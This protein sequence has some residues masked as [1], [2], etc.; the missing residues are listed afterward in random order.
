[1]LRAPE[2]CLGLYPAEEAGGGRGLPPLGDT[3]V[4]F[5]PGR[6]SVSTGKGQVVTDLGREFSTRLSE[7]TP[8]I[9]DLETSPGVVQYIAVPKIS[10]AFKAGTFFGGENWIS[11]PAGGESVEEKLPGAGFLYTPG[12]NYVCFVSKKVTAISAGSCTPKS[13]G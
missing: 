1:M 6:V 3:I 9:V 12:S 13:V 8:C 7:F 2:P 4:E 5:S 10:I 11:Y